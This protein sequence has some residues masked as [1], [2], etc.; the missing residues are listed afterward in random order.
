MKGVIGVPGKESKHR[1]S[2]HASS[3][4]SSQ[5]NGKGMLME[6]RY[7]VQRLTEQIFVVRE[8]MSAGGAPGSDDRI[9]R[10]FNV[11]H[12]ASTY[13][14]SMNDAQSNPQKAA[15]LSNKDQVS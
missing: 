14:N 15:A 1:L 6:K 13:A 2:Q 9:V 7:Y 8:S 11:L 5:G 10:S 3:Q 4:S 12:D